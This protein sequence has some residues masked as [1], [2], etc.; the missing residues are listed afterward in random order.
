MEATST[1]SNT[2]GER[3]VGHRLK[4]LCRVVFSEIVTL[5]FFPRDHKI[6]EGLLTNHSTQLWYHAFQKYLLTL[7]MIGAL[8]L[9]L[10][11]QVSFSRL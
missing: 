8:I 3:I 1:Q 4:I 7:H 10:S 11:S 9:Q 5:L 6:F 2:G